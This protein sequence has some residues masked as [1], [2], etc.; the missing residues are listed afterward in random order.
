VL[1]EPLT[2]RFVRIFKEEADRL[3]VA[4]VLGDWREEVIVLNGNEL[5]VY[6][7]SDPNP[8]PDR[9]RLWTDRN[10]RRLKQYHN[11]YSP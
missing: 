2:G 11:Y 4:D 9:E 7:N 1:F 6:E 3:Y 5:H 8:R 10:Y